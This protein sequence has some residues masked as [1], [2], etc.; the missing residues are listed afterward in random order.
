MKLEITLSLIDSEETTED[1]I[2]RAEQRR[3]DDE[4][5]RKMKKYGMFN[6]NGEWIEG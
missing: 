5:L 1:I 2:N 4:L 3:K 6:E